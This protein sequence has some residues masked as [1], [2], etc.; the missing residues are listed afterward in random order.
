MS[1]SLP[2]LRLFHK[3]CEISENN[4]KTLTIKALVCLH[5]HDIAT[6]NVYLQH[7]FHRDCV[8]AKY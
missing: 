6:E 7:T 3:M 2:I 8:I 4:L 5:N 1:H